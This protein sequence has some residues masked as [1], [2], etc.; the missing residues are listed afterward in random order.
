MRRR[1]AVLSVLILVIGYSYW[2]QQGSLMTLEKSS[3]ISTIPPVQPSDFLSPSA[4]TVGSSNTFKQ[5]YDLEVKSIGQIDED[6]EGTERRLKTFARSLKETEIKFLFETI[7]DLHK[8]HDERFLAVMLLAWTGKAETSQLLEDIAASEVDPYLSPGRQGD[9]ETALRMKA[10][11]G[12]EE[13]P[14]G[15]FAHQK[16]LQ[17]I[18]Y[19][20]SNAHVVDRAQRSLW[21]AQGKADLPQTQDED[22]M[23]ELLKKTSR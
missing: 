13:L 23:W 6:P 3:S 9:F 8:S 15:S 5:Q 20:S 22:A 16:H 17:N 12:I 11:E 19:K 21:A 1:L 4:A 10:V 7:L 2:R 14:I 18:I